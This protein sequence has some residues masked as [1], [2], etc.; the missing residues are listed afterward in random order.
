MEQNPLERRGPESL[1]KKAPEGEKRKDR[2]YMQM[3]DGTLIDITDMT[4]EERMALAEEAQAN[5]E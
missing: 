3:P 2:E 5:R 1:N 4:Q